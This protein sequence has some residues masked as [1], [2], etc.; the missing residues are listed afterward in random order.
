MIGWGDGL[1]LA[2]DYL[3]LQPNAEDLRILTWYGTGSFSY[4]WFTED[5]IIT[6]DTTWNDE[7][8]AEYL[9]AD[10][11]IIYTQQ[12][13]R[14]APQPLLN[15]LQGQKPEQTIV[16]NGVVYMWIYNLRD[17]PQPDFLQSGRYP[18]TALR[19]SPA[20]C[21][22]SVPLDHPHNLEQQCRLRAHHFW[23]IA[24]C[25]VHQASW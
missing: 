17:L 25:K 15:F 8:S 23:S 18:S 13:Q 6:L 3:R 9:N 2:A 20:N 5:T 22:N 21:P 1:N 7:Y 4:F 12:V 16:I 19:M 11:A 14:N 24:Q 10:Y